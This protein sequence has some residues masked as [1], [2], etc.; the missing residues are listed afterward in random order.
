MKESTALGIVVV[1]IFAFFIIVYV[2][3]KKV[4][5]KKPEINCCEHYEYLEKKIDS[6]NFELKQ[7]QIHYEKHN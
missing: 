3:L 2:G 7:K 5:D 1:F 4:P 6:L